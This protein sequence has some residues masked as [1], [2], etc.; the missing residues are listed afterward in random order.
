MDVTAWQ[1]QAMAQKAAVDSLVRKVRDW[2]REQGGSEDGLLRD[3]AS[4][5]A[6]LAGLVS[7]WHLR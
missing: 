4:A 7:R 1:A 3:S 2:L 5:A 6:L